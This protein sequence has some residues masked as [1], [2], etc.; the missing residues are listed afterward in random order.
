MS[1]IKWLASN[2]SPFNG[3]EILALKNARAATPYP[4]GDMPLIVLT[5]GIPI[6]P[7]AE[8]GVEREQ[9]RQRFKADLAAL[10]TKGRQIV[11]SAGTG[12]HIHIDEPQ[13][14]IRAIREVVNEAARK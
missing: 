12:H 7:T 10:S 1:Q 4:L 9:E 3:D 2:N 8:R 5:R 11:A 14:V 6:D 13:L